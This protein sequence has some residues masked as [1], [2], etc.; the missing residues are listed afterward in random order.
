MNT[1]S[2]PTL[3]QRNRPWLTRAAL[4]IFVLGLLLRLC[5]ARELPANVAYELEAAYRMELG[6]C[7]YTDF[8]FDQFIPIVVWRMLTLVVGSVVAPCC[9]APSVVTEWFLNVRVLGLASVLTTNTLCIFSFWLC[10]SLMDRF[11]K[12]VFAG[13]VKWL[14]LLALAIANLAMGFEYGD[15]QHLF[16]L[17]FVPYLLTRFLVLQG[18][19]VVFRFKVLTAILAAVGASFNPIF[20]LAALTFELAEVVA[21][22]NIKVLFEITSAV[23]LLASAVILLNLLF[24]PK[25]A[26]QALFGWILPIK[27]NNLNHDSFGF[28]GYGSTPEC[29]NIFYL[30]VL[31]LMFAAGGL[32]RF[33][34]LRPLATMACLGLIISLTLI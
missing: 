6:Q 21:R 7:P 33:Q 23:F 28:Y 10:F 26:S 19:D 18:A 13:H 24:L 29:R 9:G 20:L 4:G 25:E 5:Y 27:Y 17:C 15:Q 2:P 12:A 1:D 3:V 34:L 22:R 16:V 14:I 8:Y 31:A 30:G 32:S 11:G